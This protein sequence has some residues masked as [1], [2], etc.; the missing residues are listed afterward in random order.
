MPRPPAWGKLLVACGVGGATSGGPD[1]LIDRS[2]LGTS[3]QEESGRTRLQ[4]LGRTVDILPRSYS[5]ER[6]LHIWSYSFGFWVI[7]FAY[8][9]E[10]RIRYPRNQILAVQNDPADGV[11]DPPDIFCES[12]GRDRCNRRGSGRTVHLQMVMGSF[13]L[14]KTSELSSFV[15]SIFFLETRTSGAWSFVF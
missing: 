3:V 5:L 2:S 4:P 7:Q 8:S 13:R 1:P 9:N 14:L 10:R 6:N 12:C 11:G 15:L